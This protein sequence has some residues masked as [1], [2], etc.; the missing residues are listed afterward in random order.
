MDTVNIALA[1]FS[2]FMATLSSVSQSQIAFNKL[3]LYLAVMSIGSVLIFLAL[4]VGFSPLNIPFVGGVQGRY[5]AIGFMT[6]MIFIVMMLSRSE[7]FA[8]SWLGVALID[9]PVLAFSTFTYLMI[10][11]HVCC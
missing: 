7:T 11:S 2:I 10:I 9:K 5:F 8:K 3:K 1:I 4:W 6:A